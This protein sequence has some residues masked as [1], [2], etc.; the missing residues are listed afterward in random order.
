MAAEC[1]FCQ[2]VAGEAEAS[3]AYEDDATMAFVDLRQFHAGHTLVVPRRHIRDIYGLD[4]KTGSAL[5]AAISRVAEGVREAF[6]PD[7]INIW[8]SN[9]AP[10]QEVFHLH[11]HV[12]PRW[13]EDGLLRFTPPSR[14]QPTRPELDDQ[15]AK[16]RAALAG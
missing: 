15:A 2:I 13:R 14:N 7:G 5:M 6:Q 10:W 4:E 3:F 1:I 9:G 12:L 11:F 16:I 8:Q